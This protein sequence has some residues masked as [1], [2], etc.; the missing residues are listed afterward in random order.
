MIQIFMVLFPVQDAG[1]LSKFVA[2]C[3]EVAAGSIH[4]HL[5]V[6]MVLFVCL[7]SMNNLAEL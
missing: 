5:N 7:S 3:L 1:F 4:S 2:T 6:S